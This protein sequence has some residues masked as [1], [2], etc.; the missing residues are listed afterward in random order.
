LRFLEYTSGVKKDKIKAI[1]DEIETKTSFILLENG[2]YKVKGVR[3]IH[4]KLQWNT[5]FKPLVKKQSGL[6]D[7]NIIECNIGD[8]IDKS[9]KNFTPNGVS[10]FVDAWRKAFPNT[11]DPIIDGKEAKACKTLQSR[12]GDKCTTLYDN[13]FHTTDTFISQN[14][15]RP[16]LLLSRAAV[17]MVTSDPKHFQQEL[18][19]KQQKQEFEHD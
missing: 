19:I 14:A 13:Y 17:Y 1:L 4:K 8:N 7:Y 15:F 5:S 10:I 18:E 11:P 12:Y 6:P 9:S 2:C 3:H 16:S